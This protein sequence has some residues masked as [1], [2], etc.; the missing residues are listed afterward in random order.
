MGP[1]RRGRD[2]RGAL[3]LDLARATVHLKPDNLFLVARRHDAPLLKILDFGISK[4]QGGAT[5]LTN[6]IALLGTPDYMAPEQ[7]E[8]HAA[9]ID[10]RSDVF[11]LGAIAFHALTGRRP[12]LGPSIPAVLH[13]ICSREPPR[14]SALVAGLPAEVDAVLAIALAKRPDDRYQDAGTL[15]RELRAAIAGAL[16]EATRLRAARLARLEPAPIRPVDGPAHAR[17]VDATGATVGAQEG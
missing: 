12:F 6:E 7:A 9:A 16:P 3:R 17:T 1:A 10:P 4:V 14:P 5:H 11:A 15:A 2:R 13:A 8:G